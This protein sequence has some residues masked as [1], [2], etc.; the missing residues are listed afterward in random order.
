M[1]FDQTNLDYNALIEFRLKG[2]LFDLQLFEIN[3]FL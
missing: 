3:T 1:L 2:V